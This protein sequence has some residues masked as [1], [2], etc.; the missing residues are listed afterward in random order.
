MAVVTLALGI[1]LTTASTPPRT[2]ILVRPLP[3]REPSRVTL[4]WTR[5]PTIDRDLQ[6]P[7]PE[8]D[9][10]Q[11]RLRAFDEV[12]GFTGESFTL[13]GAGDDRVVE[14]GLVTDRFFDVLGVTPTVGRTI[15]PG[16]GLDEAAVSDGCAA[17]SRRVGRPS[18]ATAC[19]SA[20]GRSLSW[21]RRR[22]ASPCPP[23][24][25]RRGCRWTPCPA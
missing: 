10:W 8:V 14:V 12:A 22:P 5:V 6:S 17:G 3:Y 25:S 13:R 4:L 16:D 23:P 20:A 24:T 7:R 21:V 1:G 9:E 11:H 19:G 2:G 18:S 15:H